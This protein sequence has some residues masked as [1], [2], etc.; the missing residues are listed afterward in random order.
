[1]R[2]TLCRIHRYETPLSDPCEFNHLGRKEIRR[3]LT[4]VAGI[5]VYAAATELLQA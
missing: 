1:M 3:L 4:L 5:A 2:P